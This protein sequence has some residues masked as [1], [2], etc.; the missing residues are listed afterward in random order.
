MKFHEKYTTLSKQSKDAD[1]EGNKI[2]LGED[3]YAI[4]EL[5]ESI[6]INLSN[7]RFT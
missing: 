3:F 5:L 4:G 2:V 6:S 1:T 7:L